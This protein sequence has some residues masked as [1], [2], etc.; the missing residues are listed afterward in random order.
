MTPF[1]MLSINESM[2]LVFYHKSLPFPF[3][4]RTMRENSLSHSCEWFQHDTGAIDRVDCKS[5]VQ[6]E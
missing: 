2:A 5:I 6:R 1:V 3:D 4:R